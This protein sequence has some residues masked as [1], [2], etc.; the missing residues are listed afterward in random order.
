MHSL[1]NISNISNIVEKS[2]KNFLI[3][4]FETLYQIIIFE[5][6]DLM[7]YRVLSYRCQ[8]I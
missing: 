2:D 8:E 4:I 7:I 3:E 6:D 1:S 5:I